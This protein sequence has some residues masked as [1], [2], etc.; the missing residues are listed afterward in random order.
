MLAIFFGL[1]CQ[2]YSYNFV[3]LFVDFAPIFFV[4]F[5]FSGDSKPGLELSNQVSLAT[6]VDKPGFKQGV[7]TA[8]MECRRIFYFI[9]IGW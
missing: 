6:L 3:L 2:K 9:D 8:T 7:K 4:F 1:F 5:S